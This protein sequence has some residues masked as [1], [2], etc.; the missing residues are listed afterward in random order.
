MIY[1]ELWNKAATLTLLAMVS[2]A[3]A[4]SQE[5]FSSLESKP[6]SVSNEQLTDN[7]VNF[8]SSSDKPLAQVESSKPKVSLA[9]KYFQEGKA[10]F[11]KGEYEPALQSFRKALYQDPSDPLLNHLMGRSAFELG[12]YEEAL[13]AF[14]RVLVLNPNLVLSRLE[15]G[16]TH[17][18]LGSKLEAKEEFQKVL[19]SDIPPAVRANVESLLAQIGAER[20]HQFSG[21]LLL[22][23]M[24]DSN[25]TLGTGPLPL[26]FSPSLKSP[27]TLRS[28]SIFSTAVVLTHKYPLAKEGLTWKNNVT[29]FFSDNTTINS[30][31]LNLGIAGTGFDYAYQRHMFTSG[32]NFTGIV[33]DDH[34]YQNN[35][36]ASLNYSYAY[37]Q[38]TN[39]RGGWNYTRRHHFSRTGQNATF[40]FV[41]SYTFGM[42]FMKDPKNTWD[43]SWLHKFDNSP[44]DGNVG[45]EYT[46]YKV[47]PSYTRVLNNFINLNLS[48]VRR[49]DEYTSP[50]VGQPDGRQRSDLGMIGTVG[51]T[52]KVNPKLLFDIASTF[53]DNESNVNASTYLVK[54]L[55]L[56]VT[57]IF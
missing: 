8:F 20:E 55:S 37:S 13:F 32:V 2:V 39:F 7:S 51:F 15:K 28:D 5:E 47:A 12:N 11:D 3:F 43:F 1:K 48:G 24:W 41:H 45:L 38:R 21:I 35:W 36:G 49:H 23:Q 53:T 18:A 54:Q 31:D 9:K 4:Y 6:S 26:A 56:T 46:R 29:W 17:L 14:E 44:R 25:A 50:A 30:N 16:R 27:T 52:W 33:L 22:S 19:E 40:G 57:S 34:G 42:S 10:F